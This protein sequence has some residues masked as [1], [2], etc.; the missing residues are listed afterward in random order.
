MLKC[1]WRVMPD[2]AS[3]NSSCAFSGG[4]EVG[5]PKRSSVR[6]S[7]RS[8]RQTNLQ[9]VQNNAARIPDWLFAVTDATTSLLG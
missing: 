1:R 5:L 2:R 4:F 6:Y 9:R 7:R 8:Y 3:R